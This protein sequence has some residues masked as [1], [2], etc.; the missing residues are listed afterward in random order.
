[1]EF[2]LPINSFYS[3]ICFETLRSV[4]DTVTEV[5]KSS[6]VAALMELMIQPKK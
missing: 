5:D 1:M 4:R 3:A 2:P 6:K